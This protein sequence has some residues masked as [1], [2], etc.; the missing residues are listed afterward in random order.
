MSW[1]E[2][3]ELAGEQFS[4]LHKDVHLGYQISGEKRTWLPLRCVSD[5]KTAVKTL[6]EKAPA[7]RTRPVTM[8]VTDLVSHGPS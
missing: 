2:F 5:W 4:T 7:A 3:E 6:Q 8:E 1:P